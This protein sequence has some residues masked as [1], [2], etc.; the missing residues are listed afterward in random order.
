MKCRVIG[1]RANTE[2]WIRRYLKEGA[3]GIEIDIYMKEGS[4][5]VGHPLDETKPILLR[6]R[7]SKAL[8]GIHFNKG[9][10]I[11]QAAHYSKGRILWLD[12]KDPGIYHDVL[13]IKEIRYDPS[14]IIITTRFHDEALEIKK[15]YPWAK[16]L[17][18]MESLPPRILDLIND[19]RAEGISLKYEI[20]KKKPDLIR[21]L[22][23]NRIEIGLWV[24][25][26]EDQLKKAI[27]WGVKYIVTD[28]VSLAL[29]YCE[30]LTNN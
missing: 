22:I 26:D 18:S 6:E 25:N 29:R 3:H 1:H 14:E 5:E 2:R 17:L 15:K 23:N 8:L 24:I 16:V 20:A 19:V 7:I 10:N 12:L 30:A 27:N 11:I 4:L 28:F 21:N 13:N 9:V